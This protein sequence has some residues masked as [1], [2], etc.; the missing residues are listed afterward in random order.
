MPQIGTLWPQSQ[1]TAAVYGIEVKRPDVL[2]GSLG[3]G[4]VSLTFDGGG[5]L[6][7]VMALSEVGARQLVRDLVALL[8]PD[9]PPAAD[10]KPADV[11]PVAAELPAVKPGRGPEPRDRR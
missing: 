5:R 9:A 7:A 11:K 2:G 3:A 6:V 8:G 1:Q 4:A 10:V